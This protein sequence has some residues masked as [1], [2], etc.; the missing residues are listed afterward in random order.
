MLLSAEYTPILK[1]K[2]VKTVK[3]THYLSK[4]S[5]LAFDLHASFDTDADTLSTLAGLDNKGLE[6]QNYM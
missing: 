3:I 6:Y 4:I 2:L 5:F 1:D